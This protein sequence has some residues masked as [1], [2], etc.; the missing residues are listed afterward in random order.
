M[1]SLVIQPGQEHHLEI[2]T[3]IL[4]TNVSFGD[5]VEGSERSVVKVLMG[6][7][8]QGDD[9]DVGPA[10]EAP[11]KEVVIA[12]LTPGQLEVTTTNVLLSHDTDFVVFSVTGPNQV[13][14]TGH[15]TDEGKHH[16]VEPG[17]LHNSEEDDTDS[18]L[19]NDEAYMAEVREEAEE[20]LQAHLRNRVIETPEQVL[21][22]EGLEG[23]VFEEKTPIVGETPF[24]DL[25]LM[26][27]SDDDSSE[28]EDEEGSDAGSG[29]VDV[30]GGSDDD[31]SDGDEGEF[32]DEVREELKTL[33]RQALP[34]A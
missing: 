28:D 24:V 12:A 6:I 4:L 7:D 26:S 31:G 17:V 9:D 34:Q 25:A 1:W 5:K 3:P 20:F 22:Q 11:P 10:Y 29:D 19:A 32:A 14:L 8:S 21:K 16:E 30:L 33:R 13:H 23:Y 2:T 18:I 27:D 15:Y